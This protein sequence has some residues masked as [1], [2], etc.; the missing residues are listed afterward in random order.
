V[1]ADEWESE[2]ETV[3]PSDKRILA[4]PLILIPPMPMK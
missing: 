4:S 2:P 3:K 1:S